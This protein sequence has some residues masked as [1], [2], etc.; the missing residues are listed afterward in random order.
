M[1]ETKKVQRNKDEYNERVKE[2]IDKFC[3]NNN[4]DKENL[5]FLVDWLEW[6]TRQDEKNRIISLINY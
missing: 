1:R 2:E 3:Q 4:I 5:Y 6:F